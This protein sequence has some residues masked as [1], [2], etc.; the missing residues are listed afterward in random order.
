MGH[1][2]GVADL[3]RS[4]ED[5]DRYVLDV[6]VGRGDE[7]VG[8]VVQCWCEC[9]AYRGSLILAA[10]YKGKLIELGLFFGGGIVCLRFR[11]L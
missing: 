11:L 6:G 9:S 10:I 4:A 7:S 8:L 2:F 3:F 1:S 5:E